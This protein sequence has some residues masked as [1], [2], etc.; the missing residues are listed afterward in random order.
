MAVYTF[1]GS[2]TSNWN[3]T[4]SWSGGIIPTS[5]DIC[6]FNATSPTCSV[7]VSNITITDINFTGY[8]RLFNMNIY[9]ILLNGI[10][11]FSSSMS[12]TW[13][14]SGGTWGFNIANPTIN[15]NGKLLSG[16][17]IIGGGNINIPSGLNLSSRLILSAGLSHSFN[18]GW[19]CSRLTYEGNILNTNN[20]VLS[21]TFSYYVGN[22]IELISYDQTIPVRLKSSIPGRS[23]NFTFAGTSQSLFGVL[24]TDINSSAGNT[25]TSTNYF[26][27]STNTLNWIE[28]DSNKIN[29]I[30]TYAD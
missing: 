1:Q 6:I 21:P 30:T 17:N 5:A 15:T 22:Q 20:I 26:T 27:A 14:S 12:L 23:V 11:T 28:L 25:L 8:T 4:S 16:V 7:D 3:A 24:T 2:V 29:N 9:S 19:T 10:A 18:N 13:S